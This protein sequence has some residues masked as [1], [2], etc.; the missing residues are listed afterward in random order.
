MLYYRDKG[1]G[2]C[3]ENIPTQCRREICIKCKNVYKGNE[4]EDVY[5]LD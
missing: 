3:K 1:I 5:L 2:T 4:S